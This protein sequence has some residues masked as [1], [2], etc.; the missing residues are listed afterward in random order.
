MQG[1]GKG[2]EGR[3]GARKR[4]NTRGFFLKLLKAVEGKQLPRKMQFTS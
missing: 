4:G 1:A 3:R 2:L